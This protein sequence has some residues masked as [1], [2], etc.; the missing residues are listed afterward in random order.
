MRFL[1]AIVAAF[2]LLA[3]ASETAADRYRAYC[4]ELATCM[5]ESIDACV[6][7][8]E[9]EEELA[10][11]EGCD[12]EHEALIACR[13]ATA[14]CEPN[15]GFPIYVSRVCDVEGEAFVNCP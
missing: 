1:L 3:C 8:H 5:G 7:L 6:T 13:E 15:G 9:I 14:L 10:A 2:C 11:E 12:D 4:T